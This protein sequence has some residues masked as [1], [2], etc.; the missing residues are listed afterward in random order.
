MVKLCKTKGVPS[1]VTV[2]ATEMKNKLGHYLQVALVEPVVVEKTKQQ[3][4]VLMSMKEYERLTKLEDAYWGER[5][6]AA[7]AEGYLN[8]AETKEFIEASLRVEA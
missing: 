2:S 5:A 7:E 1:M 8:E 6:K 3:V 4:A